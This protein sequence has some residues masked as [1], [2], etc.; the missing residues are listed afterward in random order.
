MAI[1]L[2]K[3][4]KKIDEVSIGVNDDGDDYLLRLYALIYIF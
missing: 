1:T 4:Y 2:T 3:S